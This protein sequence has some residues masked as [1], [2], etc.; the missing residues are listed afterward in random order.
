M[1]NGKKLRRPFSGAVSFPG[2]D[3]EECAAP[4]FSPDLGRYWRL[5]LLCQI[6]FDEPGGV[7]DPLTHF[8]KP[9]ASAQR[10]P[11]WQSAGLDIKDAGGFDIVHSPVV[12]IES[13]IHLSHRFLADGDRWPPLKP[14]R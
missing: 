9:R 11:G 8:S 12:G 3:S 4:G 7:F 14:K 6:F 13:S 1:A 2:L 5:R 10:A